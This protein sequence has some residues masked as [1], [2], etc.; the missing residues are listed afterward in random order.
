MAITGDLQDISVPI[1]LQ[2][3]LQEGGQ[4][5]IRLTNEGESATVYLEDG[6][7]TYA[8][9]KA[10]NQTELIG[11]QA[12][13]R[14]L[15]WQNGQFTL[16]RQILAPLQTNIQQSWDYLLM[17][18]LR[19]VDEA[20]KPAQELINQEMASFGETTDLVA[21]PP[22]LSSSTPVVSLVETSPPDNLFSE[23]KEK[24]DMSKAE[25]LRDLL[26]NMVNS[27]TDIIGAVVVD[28]DGLMLASMLN[29]SVDGNRV[30]AVSAGLI[31]L[32]SRSV[33]QLG[34]GTVNQTIIQ[35][36]NGNI[37]ALRVGD[38]A[39]FVALT[40]VEVNL[41]MALLECRDAVKSIAELL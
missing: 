16:L 39:S 5:Q 31:S 9:Y 32:A 23:P 4:A 17:E 8:H 30:A 40:P 2:S 25:Q 34:Q 21:S 1:L 11:E 27:S 22:P 41:G 38:K 24:N 18:G 28:R 19:Q 6:R 14:L 15:H 20:Q 13:F 33:Q 26:R 29:S 35:A 7:L 3:I 36:T 10:P 12:V 37:I